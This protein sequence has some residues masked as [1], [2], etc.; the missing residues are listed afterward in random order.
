MGVGQ[1]HH[2]LAEVCLDDLHA[3]ALEVIVKT[4]LLARHRLAFGHDHASS[5]WNFARGVPAKLAD[6]LARFC[7]VPREMHH[8]ANRAEALRELLEQLRHTFEVR[9]PPQLEVGA[10]LDDA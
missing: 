5:R 8:A 9:L 10:A 3:E 7:G 2:S 6:D 4:D 1:L